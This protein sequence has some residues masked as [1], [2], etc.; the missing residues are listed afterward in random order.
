MVNDL[1]ASCFWELVHA[2]PVIAV[3]WFKNVGL[4]GDI[5][6][7]RIVP[8]TIIS[9]EGS[10]DRDLLMGEWDDWIFTESG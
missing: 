6:R 7:P 9:Q 2:A 10:I 4:L 8:S 5:D 3:V 1:S